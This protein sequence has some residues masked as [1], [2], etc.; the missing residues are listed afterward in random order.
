MEPE[1]IIMSERY[2]FP[3]RQTACLLES[4]LAL[5]TFAESL[6]FYPLNCQFNST[7]ICL[8][9]LYSR[10]W[11]GNETPQVAYGLEGKQTSKQTI[12]IQSVMNKTEVQAMAEHV[13]ESTLS[14]TGGVVEMLQHN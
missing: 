10:H 9:T 8:I 12:A 3:N 7:E 1:N 6:I 13:D 11:R 5:D 14:E 2:F 4:A